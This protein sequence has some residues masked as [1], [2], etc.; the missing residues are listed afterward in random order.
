MSWKKVVA[1]PWF[2]ALIAVGILV[3]ILSLRQIHDLDLGFHLRGGQW[4]LQ[5]HSFHRFDVFT[6]TVNNHE[7]VAM[8][9]LFQ[10]ALY[11]AYLITGYPGLTVINALLVLL[12]FAILFWRMK[13]GG[14]GPG[15][16][17]FSLFL[18]ALAMELR[19]GVR[20]EIATW[21]LM[22]L[23]LWVFEEYSRSG[24][25][26]LFLLPVIQLVWVNAHGLFILGWIVVAAYTVGIF[27][28]DRPRFRKL[29]PWSLAAILASLVNPYGVHGL[30]FPFYLFTRLQA[31]NIFRDAITELTPPFSSKA[32]FLMPDLPLY[33]FYGFAAASVLLVLATV[34]R[35]RVQELM[36]TGS[37][38]YLSITAVRNIP[39]FIIA[40][41][42]II[43]RASQDLAG[44]LRARF[45]AFMPGPMIHRILAYAL[46]AV[47]LLFSMRVVTNAFYAE[48]GGGHF[49]LGLDPN[50]HPVGA[51][52]F[53]NQHHLT[54]R[55]L[56]DLNHGSWLIWQVKQPVFIDGR[57]EV[58][59]E[60]FFSE[61]YR[62]YSSGGLNALIA[63][64]QPD[65]VIFDHSYPEAALW[66]IDLKTNP[67]WRLAYADAVSAFWLRK[68]YGDEL[69]R[70]D[71]RGRISELG[72]DPSITSSAW[73]ILNKK[74]PNRF[75]TWLAGFYRHQEAPTALYRLGL[76]AALCYDFKSAEALYLTALARSSQPPPD[77]W[78]KLGMVYYLRSDLEKAQRCFERVL[79]DD[80]GNET[81]RARRDEVRQLLGR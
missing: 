62:S 50:I 13:D 60:E 44:I 4:M 68:G 19:F 63:G 32:R 37:F 2:P 57:L 29:I 15:P 42:P 33:L 53:I 10:I 23:M 76:Y 43:V 51:A 21:L 74:R 14:I 56:N 52:D 70:F 40:C 28:H 67:A 69:P 18:A 7:Y 64:Y 39:L 48:R 55:I 54:G 8:Y 81:A 45:R 1:S 11:V 71:F 26:I 59:R 61:Y 58:M 75:H 78:L 12:V 30:A 73:R 41:L 24:R 3:L 9:W 27:V 38:L 66:D 36:I 35:R 22:S 72:I 80:S 47:C 79:E 20:P 17:A 16:A 65:L 6:Y 5:H 49:G 46:T 25:R 34:R 77:A 31:S